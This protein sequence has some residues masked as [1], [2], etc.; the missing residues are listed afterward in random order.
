MT[1]EFKIKKGLVVTGSGGTLLDVQGSVGQLFSVTD[2]L[3]GDLFSVSDVSGI[4]IFNVNA[5]G[6]VDIDGDLN[7]LNDNDKIQLGDSQ[8]LQLYHDGTNSL[9]KDN[10]TGGLIINANGANRLSIIS[11]VH[12]LGGTDFAIAAGR[13]LYLDGQSNTYITESSADTIKFFTGGT[14]VLQLANNTATFAGDIYIPEYIYHSGDT[15]TYIRFTA[16]TQTF[17]TGGDDRLILT[18]TTATFA[19]NLDV[20]K[21]LSVGSGSSRFIWHSG[22]ST[23]S[24]SGTGNAVEIDWKDSTHLI[25][26]VAYAFRVKLVV[27]GTGT[28]SGASYIVYYNNSTSAWVVRH[29]ALAGTTSNHAQLTMVSDGTGSY[30]A[31]YHTHSGDYTIRYWVETFDSGDQDM[32]GHAFGSD[33]QWQRNV[34]TLTYADG[35]VSITNNISASNLSGTNTGDQTLPT[36]SSLG[37]VTKTGTQTISGA[38]TF[39]STGNYH[40]GHLY[41]N[42][43]DAAGNHYP[44]FLD[45]ADAGGTTVNWRQYYGSTYKNHTWTS[46]SSGNMLFTFQGGITAAGALTGTSLDINGAADISGTL[47]IG[48]N[49][50]MTG[51]SPTISILDNDSNADDFYIHI[52]SNNFYILTNRTD[53]PADQ[54][55][56]GWETPHA[57]QLE[58]DTNT[59]YVFGNEILDTSTTFVGDVTGTAGAMVV[60]N[61]SH[62]HDSR[63]YTETEIDTNHYGK[64]ATNAKFLTKD[65]SA[66]EWVFEVNDEGNISGNKWYKVATVNKGNG[67]LHIRGLFSNHVEGFASQKVDIGMV[68]REGGANDTLEVTG[69]VDVL[70]RAA[71]GSDNCGIRIVE[72]DITSS[73]H[74][75]YFDVYVKTTRYQMLRLHLTKSGATTFHTSPT[76]VTTEPVPVSG[77]TTGLEIDTSTY[78][79]GNYLISNSA[80]VLTATT[81]GT[82][83]VGSLTAA[84]DVI[85][86]SDERLKEN[87]KTLDGSKVLQMRGV[88]FDRLDNGKYSSGVIAQ[89]LEKVAPELVIDDGKYKGVAYGNITGYLIEAIKEQQKQINELK[90]QMTT[91][92]KTNC[93]CNCKN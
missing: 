10:G 1:N 52:N 89:E 42:S 20:G 80:P 33:F 2:S 62:T 23:V 67:G 53:S 21:T 11:D 64:V 3:T 32:D 29:V 45:G 40:N 56:T 85:A 6:T 16:D 87:V 39:T 77:G 44:H 8:D 19:G 31:A 38:K 36:A 76:V 24:G 34:N 49:L 17:R 88:S 70:H 54:V 79:E 66:K 46:D 43:Y 61:D 5:N 15:N 60:G 51:A 84:A 83:V 73:A 30:M 14:E 12:I 72:A 55:N 47:N 78:V 50:V 48:D 59:A 93:N 69:T 37:A 4:P 25:P 86:Y 22:A 68:G 65:G 75:H 13:K 41:Y 74:Y 27:T 28:D 81:T 90:S 35:N 26:S 92:N 9:I 63:Y 18:N 71:T 58:A 91:C 57:L 7:L 82:S